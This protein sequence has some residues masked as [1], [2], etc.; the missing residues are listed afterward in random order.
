MAVTNVAQ[1]TWER[2]CFHVM[3]QSGCKPGHRQWGVEK[4]VGMIMAKVIEFY[5]PN[6]FP[7]KRD[8]DPP[9]TT[10]ESNR[11]LPTGKEVGLSCEL[12]CNQPGTVDIA[13]HGAGN[14]L[15]G[16]RQLHITQTEWGNKGDK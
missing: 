11:V 7:E 14:A 13:F 10:R 8:L 16:T 6:T 1:S 15:L 12:L 5:I 9:R 4:R 2:T 3:R